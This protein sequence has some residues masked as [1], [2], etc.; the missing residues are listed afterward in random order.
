MYHMEINDMMEHMPQN[1][2]GLSVNGGER[3]AKI[4]PTLGRVLRQRRRGVVEVG[5]HHYR[6]A[7]QIRQKRRGPLNRAM[8][9]GEETTDQL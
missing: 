7:R 6:S 2:P 1:E 5:D 3:A 9:N 8:D 4:R